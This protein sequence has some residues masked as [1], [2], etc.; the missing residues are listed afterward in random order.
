MRVRWE[1]PKR[2]LLQHQAKARLFKAEQS[3]NAIE[4]RYEVLP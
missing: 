4:M 2:L 1:G 3:L